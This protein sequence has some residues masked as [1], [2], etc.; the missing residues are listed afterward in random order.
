M[1]KSPGHASGLF[2]LYLCAVKSRQEIILA[3]ATPPGA[4]AIAVLRVSGPG[5]LS[6]ID[7]L[8][9]KPISQEAG[10][11]AHFRALHDK[12]GVIDEALLTLFKAPGGYTGDKH[13]WF[14]IHCGAPYAIDLCFGCQA[15]R[16]W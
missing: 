11:T 6:L 5:T 12:K 3:R 8:L 14:R 9:K 7:K 15:R 16:S 4:G 2:V 1:S 10:H 13:A